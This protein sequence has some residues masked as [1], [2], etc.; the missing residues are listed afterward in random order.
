LRHHFY[1]LASFREPYM[2]GGF[3]SP[4]SRSH[5]VGVSIR[6]AVGAQLGGLRG[7]G[8][9]VRSRSFRLG[10]TSGLIRF[11]SVLS[12]TVAGSGLRDLAHNLV[13]YF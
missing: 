11:D 5:V 8:F 4:I 1:T 2:L 12:A 3:A 13:R 10:S 7:R 6:P 9:W